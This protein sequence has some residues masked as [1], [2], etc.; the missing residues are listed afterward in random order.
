MSAKSAKTSATP[1]EWRIG[2][3]A[4]LTGVTTR[5]LRYWEEL[6]E[7][8]TALHAAC[9]QLDKAASKGVLHKNQAANRKSA[10]A[11]RYAEGRQA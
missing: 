11:K 1:V 2:E 3:V 4:K 7:A 8:E 9:R 5:T 6:S 10:I